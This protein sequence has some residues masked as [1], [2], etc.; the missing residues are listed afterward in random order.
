MTTNVFLTVDVECGDYCINYE[1]SV[2]GRLKNRPGENYGL[3]YILETLDRYGLKCTFFVEAFASARFGKKGLSDICQKIKKFNQEIQL[4]IHED[5]FV[6]T[7]DFS[8]KSTRSERILGDYSVEEQIRLIKHGM[9]ILKS[10]GVSDINAFR[11]GGFGADNKTL[12]ALKLLNIR[13]DSSYNLNYL[14]N[15]CSIKIKNNK[16]NQLSY[17]NGLYELPITN[18]KVKAVPWINY[19]HI[20]IGAVSFREM[21][22]ILI[23]ARKIRLNNIC[24]LLHSNEFIFFENKERTIG[25]PNKI[26]MARFEKLLHFLSN[27]S[28]DYKTRT[29]TDIFDY[30]ESIKYLKKDEESNIVP[31]VNPVNWFIRMRQQIQK[32]IFCSINGCRP[33]G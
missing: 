3:E 30:E 2:Y 9:E 15:G 20:Q 6:N 28:K 32:R 23:Q 19:R 25:Q 33:L 17:L 22:D 11:A 18:V 13:I 5:F 27:N 16:I 31:L 4:H 1:G 26:N 12:E 10:C 8:V 29:V 24:L 7:N 14:G 21:R